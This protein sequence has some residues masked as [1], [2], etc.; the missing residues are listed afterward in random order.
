MS[1]EVL[2][3]SGFV[4]LIL[5][6]LFLLLEM[7]TPGLFFFIS[8]SVGCLVA[9]I[10]AFL[11]FNIAVQ[12]SA[13]IVTSIIAIFVLKKLFTQSLK[14]ANHE[15]TNIERII[16]SQGIV[17]KEII[18]IKPGQVKVKGEIWSAKSITKEPIEKG[19]KIKVI[20]IEGNHLIVEIEKQ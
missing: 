12:A 8:F 16:H 7:G 3:N 2:S 13:A 1:F 11:Y 18:P 14:S 9:G 19:E 10:L 15:K 6:V 20:R 4:W 17:I 5:A